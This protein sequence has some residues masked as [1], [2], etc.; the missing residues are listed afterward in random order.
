MTSPGGRGRG[1]AYA[2]PERAPRGYAPAP[3][4]RGRLY[5]SEASQQGR[6]VGRHRAGSSRGGPR[7]GQ[8]DSRPLPFWQELP[9]LV[10]IAFSLALL[11]KTFLLQAFFIPS[12]SMERTLLIK[13]RV[14]VNKIVYDFRAPQRGEVIVFRGVDSWAPET[15]TPKPVGLV[16][17]A[18]RT[19]GGL[20]GL[21]EPDEKDFIKRVIGTPGDVVQCCDAQGRLMVNG[22]PLNETYLFQDDRRPFGP[23]TVP[24]GR[25]F[26]MGDH[27]GNSQDSRAYI[28]DQFKGTIPISQVIGRAFV[29][30]WPV[31]RWGGLPVPPAWQGVPLAGA[32]P[33]AGPSRAGVGGSAPGATSG[34]QPVRAAARQPVGAPG[35]GGAVAGPSAA[36]RGS[37]PANPLTAS[38]AAL[39][40]VPV[41]TWGRRRTRRNRHPRGAVRG[42]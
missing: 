41:V 29:K 35:G 19:V 20:V 34:A 24:A 10:L 33:A 40:F 14:L 38:A 16:A 39:A 22:K 30:V 3:K 23:I 5:V 8:P 42:G 15:T 7:G 37:L 26:V 4:Q 21:A 27:R 1:F 6:H 11:I 25:L 13:D 18:S 31:D 28:G 32:A 36:S 17:K 12:G 9:L 2:A